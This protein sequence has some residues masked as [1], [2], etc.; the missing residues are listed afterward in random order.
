[1]HKIIPLTQN[2]VAIINEDDFDRI[3]VY[4]WYA[5]RQANGS[6]YACR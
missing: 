6:F 1:M 2:Q 3:S 5:Q 4:N